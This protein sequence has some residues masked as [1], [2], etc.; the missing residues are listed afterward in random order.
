VVAS[1]AQ[2]DLLQLIGK[3][4]RR[5]PSRWKYGYRRCGAPS[6]ATSG[7]LGLSRIRCF[8]T[9]MSAPS[10]SISAAAAGPHSGVRGRLSCGSRFGTSHAGSLCDCQRSSVPSSLAS[11][12]PSLLLVGVLDRLINL[13][14]GWTAP[15]L[16]TPS[17]RARIYLRD[18][19]WTAGLWC[20]VV[21]GS[22]RQVS[23]FLSV[24][25]TSLGIALEACGMCRMIDDIG[26]LTRGSMSRSTVVAIGS[27][28]R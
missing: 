16:S 27:G 9:A 18:D 23:H 21:P 10:A 28:P 5:L 13:L 15:R 26:E 2:R 14:E 12:H 6:R 4:S 11:V 25:R 22:G 8:Y 3:P 19:R 24:E 20:C 7:V 17:T 1:P